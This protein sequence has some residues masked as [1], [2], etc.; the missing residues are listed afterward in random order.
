MAPMA[1]PVY[2]RFIQRICNVNTSC[3]HLTY[4]YNTNTILLFSIT[5]G[6]CYLIFKSLL[7]RSFIF[8]EINKFRLSKFSKISFAF[9][10]FVPIPVQEMF[11]L[12]LYK[13]SHQ[14]MFLCREL[15]IKKRI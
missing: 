8:S 13:K 3:E 2:V 14:W 7:I 10:I 11:F 12:N 6:S 15:S 9:N 5:F 4:L 1:T